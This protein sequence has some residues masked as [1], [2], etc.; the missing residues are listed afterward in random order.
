MEAVGLGLADSRGIRGGVV[1]NLEAAVESI[2]KAIDE[3][4]LTA[5]VEIDSVHLGLSGA[6]VKAFNSRGV[7]AVAGK[8]REIT[9]T[10]TGELI[11]APEGPYKVRPEEEGGMQI[12]GQGELAFA[13]SQ[14]AQV[15]GSLD[16]QRPEDDRTG[17]LLPRRARRHGAL[18]VLQQTGPAQVGVE[19]VASSLRYDDAANIVKMGGYGIVNLT[20]DWAFAKAKAE[21][22]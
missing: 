15:Q 11:A 17:N 19:V 2:R 8:N 21:L 13:T 22:A 20:L 1:V 18:T 7:V 12:E 16:L 6:H 4:E 5:G 3:A 10:G 14:G 9:P